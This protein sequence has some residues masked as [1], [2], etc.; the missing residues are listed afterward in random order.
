MVRVTQFLSH[1]AELRLAGP[2]AYNYF[3]LLGI[4]HREE[5]LPREIVVNF[6]F[7]PV[8]RDGII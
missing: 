8:N 7:G 3:A 4:E 1:L 6:G 2:H 5:L